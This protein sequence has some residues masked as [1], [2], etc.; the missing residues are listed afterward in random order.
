MC[1]HF[2]CLT[3]S[4]ALNGSSNEMHG[5]TDATKHIIFLLRSQFWNNLQPYRYHCLIFMNFQW[6]VGFIRYPDYLTSHNWTLKQSISYVHIS[7]C[8]KHTRSKTS[9]KVQ[10]RVKVGIRS[11]LILYKSHTGNRHC[12]SFSWKWQISCWKFLKND[13]LVSVGL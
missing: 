2:E 10:H 3:I 6:H 1:N 13:L 7:S 12:R 5:W 9:F 11:L 4:N 8:Q